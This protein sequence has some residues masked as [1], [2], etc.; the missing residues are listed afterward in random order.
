VIDAQNLMLVIREI[1]S[2]LPRIKGLGIVLAMIAKQFRNT[3]LADVEVDVL[4]N[5]MLLNPNDFIGNTLIF[6]P[7]WFDHRERRLLDKILSCGDYVVDLGANIG[8]YT[9]IFSKL[10]GKQ[11]MVTSIE[12]ESDN[13][14]RL[15]HNVKI[16]NMQNV[17]IH[18]IGVS[19]KSE[20][21]LLLLN[22]TGNAG[23]HSFYEQS[24][25]GTPPV[26]PVECRPLAELIDHSKPLKLIKLDIEGFEYRV[27]RRFFDDLERSKWPK[28]IMLEDVPFR[29]ENDATRL[30]L[31][32]GYSLMERIDYNVFLCKVS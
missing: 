8:A 9:L 26:Q 14:K 6:T 15:E 16:N 19:D 13:A 10:V 12:A 31:D 29:R 4:G 21:L 28:Y 32:K 11:G 3:H 17:E 23:G 30:A 22:T 5:K 20:S 1:T 7:Q 24:D 2:R 27:L 18:H 25:V